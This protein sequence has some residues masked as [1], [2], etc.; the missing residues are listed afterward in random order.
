MASE[1]R[2]FVQAGKVETYKQEV[3]S[4]RGKVIGK[5]GIRVQGITARDGQRIIAEAER[6][7]LL[8]ALT[9]EGI[10]IREEC[11]TSPSKA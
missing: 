8:A 10:G 2:E 6:L 3:K 5:E 4:E 9:L 1:L 11:K 7:E